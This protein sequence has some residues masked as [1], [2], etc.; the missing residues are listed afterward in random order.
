MRV[1]VQA[2]ANLK[3]YAPGGEGEVS[4]PEGSTVRDLL[5]RLAIPPG[6]EAVVLVNGRRAGGEQ[7][8]SPGDRLVLFPPMEGG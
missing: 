3:A 1:S 4:L 6:V 7:R 8:L 2:F 5:A